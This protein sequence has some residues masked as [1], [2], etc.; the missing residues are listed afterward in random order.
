VAKQKILVITTLENSL[1]S[2]SDSWDWED[3]NVVDMAKPIGLSG[4]GKSPPCYDCPLKAI[5]DGWRLMGPSVVE[6]DYAPGVVGY[7]WWF[8]R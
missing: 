2:K 4:A 3:A 8:E 7:T 5:A 6:N 1:R